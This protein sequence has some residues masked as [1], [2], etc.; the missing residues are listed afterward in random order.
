M[1][2]DSQIINVGDLVFIKSSATGEPMIEAGI[3]LVVAKDFGPPGDA[4]LIKKIK[5]YLQ[6]YG[7][8]L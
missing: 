7:K 3:C 1:E 5:K 8:D 2:D 4:S 6:S